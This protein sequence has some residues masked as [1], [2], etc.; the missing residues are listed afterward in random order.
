MPLLASPYLLVGGLA[1]AAHWGT[2]V[3]VSGP[4]VP[5]HSHVNESQRLPE[6]RLPLNPQ[7]EAP[8]FAETPPVAVARNIQCSTSKRLEFTA[9]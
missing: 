1:G 2:G 3:A 4:S 7:P 9:T 5:T 6:H 8:S